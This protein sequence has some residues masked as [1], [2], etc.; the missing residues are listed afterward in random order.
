MADV[1]TERSRNSVCPSLLRR[2][3][4]SAATRGQRPRFTISDVAPDWHD[5]MVPQ[6]TMRPAYLPMSHG[7][8]STYSVL[9]RVVGQ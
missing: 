8:A 7:S 9:Y 3:V 1:S 2:D 6:R 4:S 5:L